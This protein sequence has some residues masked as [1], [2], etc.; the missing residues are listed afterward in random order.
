MGHPQPP[1]RPSG[2]SARQ[3]PLPRLLQN[4]PTSATRQ[5][6]RW[7]QPSRPSPTRVRLIP[8]PRWNPRSPRHLQKRWEDARNQHGGGSR[9][10]LPPLCLGTCR[11]QSPARRR[12][13]ARW[14][15]PSLCPWQ[16]THNGGFIEESGEERGRAKSRWSRLPALSPPGGDMGATSP[17]HR[18]SIWAPAP[19]PGISCC[20]GVPGGAFPS[21]WLSG[22]VSWVPLHPP[23][24]LLGAGS[25]SRAWAPTGTE[26]PEQDR[27]EEPVCPIP[28]PTAAGI[29][30]GEHPPRGDERPRRAHPSWTPSPK[31][32]GPPGPDCS[33]HP[34]PEGAGTVQRMLLWSRGC[35]CG[36]GSPGAG[37]DPP[38]LCRVRGGG[39]CSPWARPHK[40]PRTHSVC[41]TQRPPAFGHGREQLWPP[42]PRQNHSLAARGCSQ[43]SKRTPAPS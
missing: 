22:W 11:C 3:S 30:A 39:R 10:P 41:S 33:Q 23:P 4:S 20:W 37:E 40:D 35:C 26:I 27:S 21:A 31:P 16:T 13:P 36:P 34:H 12:M 42:H 8:P 24:L 7:D 38:G 14:V 18:G 15:S 43:L 9:H 32:W 25:G 5:P 2:C 29:L 6:P 19:L 17:G 1:W 28:A